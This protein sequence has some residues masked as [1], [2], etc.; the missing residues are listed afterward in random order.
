M[1]PKS[2]S[3]SKDQK[4][5]ESPK[6]DS[7]QDSEFQVAIRERSDSEEEY[8]KPELLKEAI[9]E[10]EEEVAQKQAEGNDDVDSET[11]DSDEDED[12]DAQLLTPAVDS[13]ILKTIAAIRSKDPRVYQKDAR[14]FNNDSNDSVVAT[15]ADKKQKK[16]K[17]DAPLTLKDYERKMLLEHGGFIED[18]DEANLKTA[19]KTHEEEQAEL[20]DAFKKA[21]V[22]DTENEEE[23]DD[24]DG[25]LQKKEKT[26][27]E[28][29][30]E[31]DD[32]RRFLLEEMKN[33]EHSKK[34]VEEWS[35]YKENPDISAEEAFLMDYVLNRG[36]V[37]KGEERENTNLEE[38]DPEK[39]EEYLD[40]VDR[41]ESKYN[42]RFEEEGSSN[43]ITH[44][45]DV[46]GTV[47]RKKSKRALRREKERLHKE[48]LKEQK[49][50]ELKEEKNRKM[51]EIRE[52]LKEIQGITGAKALGLENI[53]LEGDFDP[54]TFDA[55]MNSVF[56]E[57]YYNQQDDDP[58]VKP[59]WDDDIMDADFLPGGEKY[60]DEE[61][62]QPEMDSEEVRQKKEM[63]EKLLDEYYSLNYE[64]VIGG[65]TFTRFKYAKTEPE[66]YGL[67][68]EE[69]LLADDRE[70]N[71]YIGIKMMAP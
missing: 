52:K 57:D 62:N 6:E 38:V 67:T 21:I 23:S 31:E 50:V 14:F 63:V 1:G 36:W 68:A 65:D 7:V 58:T 64:D 61:T 24:D 16:Q 11:S 8:E 54:A 19:E 25:F 42:F 69:I 28:K 40:N 46:E 39:D 44:A 33:D 45:R 48:A 12:D 3:K 18:E 26:T 49:M 35:N 4:I 27:E 59:Q 56:D 51:K 37:D 2:S 55:H 29:Q 71:N 66:N 20:R 9:R 17:E 53:D 10:I 41:F 30:A 43:I 22:S 13:Q 34:A 32:Y 60:P 47:R 70:L 15:K 5:K